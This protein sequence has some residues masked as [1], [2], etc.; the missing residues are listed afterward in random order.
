MDQL[1]IALAA[2][3]LGGAVNAVAGGGSFITFPALILTGIPP[4]AANQT[5]SVALLPEGLASSWAYRNEIRSFYQVDLPA[6]VL[7]TVIG[8]GAGAAL[9]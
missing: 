2:G 7:P 1:L 6:M 5:S 9:C 4:V 8:G 3:L